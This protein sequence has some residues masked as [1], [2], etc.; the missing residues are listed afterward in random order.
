[1]LSVFS[2]QTF[3]QCIAEPMQTFKTY[4]FLSKKDSCFLEFNPLAKSCWDLSCKI[5]QSCSRKLVT[6]FHIDRKQTFRQV[7]VSHPAD[8]GKTV[9]TQID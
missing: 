9:T 6:G 7:L 2:I 5:M 1:V 4:K 3:V 8:R